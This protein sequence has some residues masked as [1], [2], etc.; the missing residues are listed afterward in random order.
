MKIANII[1]LDSTISIADIVG[2]LADSTSYKFININ[3]YN[4]NINKSIPTLYVG[5]TLLKANIYPDVNI[6]D[7][8]ISDIVYWTF[9]KNEKMVDYFNDLRNF[10]LNILNHYQSIYKYKPFNFMLYNNTKGFNDL[11]KLFT[12]SNSIDK[13]KSIYINNRSVYILFKNN[14]IIGLDLMYFWYIDKYKT[15]SL[16]KTILKID[17]NILI[18]DKHK[19]I[20]NTY[21]NTGENSNIMFDRYLIERYL[22]VFLMKK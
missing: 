12:T 22:C 20:Y 21:I 16:I 3:Y 6:L 18:Y 17:N 2:D 4:E 14:E 1:L 19:L 10:E 15:I 5:Y 9:S 13:I 7:K 11:I 8:Q